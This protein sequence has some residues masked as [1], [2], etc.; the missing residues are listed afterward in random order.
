MTDKQPAI[1]DEGRPCGS[2]TEQKRAIDSEAIETNH[3]FRRR[4]QQTIDPTSSHS[5]KP[6]MSFTASHKAIATYH[7]FQ[8]SSYSI[9]DSCT[10][11]P[12]ASK[13]GGFHSSNRNHDPEMLRPSSSLHSSPAPSHPMY[14]T[15]PTPC[16]LAVPSDGVALRLQAQEADCLVNPFQRIGDRRPVRPVHLVDADDVALLQET[17]NVSRGP[18]HRPLVRGVEGR[19]RRHPGIPDSHLQAVWAR[20]RSTGKA[21]MVGIEHRK[22]FENCPP[23]WKHGA[24]C[25]QAGVATDR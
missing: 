25:L 20:R 15:P 12:P 7:G 23:A 6:L 17:A 11:G 22:R 24:R 13:H 18:R 16:I 2:Q 21:A 10:V 4:P 19:V 1:F 8:I 5:N 3:V 14:L 9:S